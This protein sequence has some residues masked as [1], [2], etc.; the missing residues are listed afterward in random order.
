[1]QVQAN[2]Y[3]TYSI[4]S[5]SSW[6]FYVVQKMRCVAWLLFY[7]LDIHTMYRPAFKMTV[8]E[9]GRLVMAA[10]YSSGDDRDAEKYVWLGFPSNNSNPCYPADG[11]ST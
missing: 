7:V 10:R 6:A 11:K 5:S 4:I 2:R 3:W 8:W 9:N 1:M